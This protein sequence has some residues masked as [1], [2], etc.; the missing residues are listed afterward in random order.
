M[1]LHPGVLGGNGHPSSLFSKAAMCARTAASG[2]RTHSEPIS[3]QSLL[4]RAFVA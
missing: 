4:M 3:P 1:D 2:W